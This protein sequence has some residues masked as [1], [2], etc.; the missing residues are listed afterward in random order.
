MHN[1]TTPTK[2]ILEIN[3]LSLFISSEKKFILN[4]IS[5]QVKKGDFIIILG[6]NGSGKSSL[7]KAIN[8]SINGY[9]GSIKL[10]DKKINKLTELQI[11]QN[12]G[13]ITQDI[14]S[15]LFNAL[16]IKENFLIYHYAFNKKL[17]QKDCESE[18]R[19]RK[20]TNFLDF[21]A[22][23]NSRLVKLAE[24]KVNTLS[25][26]EKQ[27]LTLALNLFHS[28]K[29]LLLDEHTS[30]LDP[31][32]S[33]KIMELTINKIKQHN[34]TCLMTTHSLDYALKYGNKIIALKNG[35]IK[36]SFNEKEKN[37]LSKETLLN[38]CY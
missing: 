38:L 16:T 23:H 26:G 37:E 25:G 24:Q 28:K 2:N 7:L 12:I 27:T 33:D 11:A 10:D 19:K 3:Q 30:A 5:Y 6:A 14:N 32:T 36:Q 15:N 9:S 13:T 22:S 35:E 31:R 20:F 17:N 1:L 21:L 4:K 8:N 34:I 18:V 29:I